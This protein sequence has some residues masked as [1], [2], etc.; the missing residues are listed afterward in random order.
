MLSFIA[1][2]D[3]PALVIKRDG[4]WKRWSY[5]EYLQQVELVAKAMIKLG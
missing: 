2:G 3:H 4:V 5:T 1:G